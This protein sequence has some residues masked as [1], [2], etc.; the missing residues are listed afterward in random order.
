MIENRT[1][2]TTAQRPAR[3]TD[4]RRP[5]FTLI[6]LLVVILIILLVSAVTLPSI[7]SAISHRQVSEAARVLQAALVGARDSAVHNNAISGIRL[8][9]D[10][11]I[12]GLN[13]SGALDITLPLAM[14][15][16][17]PLEAAPDYDEGKVSIIKDLATNIPSS[18]FTN[19]T[20]NF[21]YP[22]PASGG[23]NVLMVEECPV[24][25][26]TFLPNEPT[27]WFW[28]IRIGDKIRIGN[29]GQYYTV[30]GPMT[31]PNPELFVNDGPAGPPTQLVRIY[32]NG[33]NNF[34]PFNVE[35]LFL[36]NGQDD[37]SDGFV[38]DGWDGVDNNLN[39]VID[40]IA[41]WTEPEK[42]L[43]S[44]AG[45]LQA[46]N[47]TVTSLPAI[48][49]NGTNAPTPGLLNQSY[50]IARRPAPSSGSREVAL[51]SNVVIDLT[52]WAT[53]HERSRFPIPAAPLVNGG[54][55]LLTSQVINPES[56]SVDILVNPDGTVVPST[57]YSSPSSFGLNGAFLHFWLA[58]RSDVA[59]PDPTRVANLTPP[60][61]PLPAGLAP[62]GWFSSGAQL[63]GECSLVT[64]Y[65][66]TGQIL[67]NSPPRFDNP[68]NPINGSY[69]NLNLP[70]LDAQQGAMGGNR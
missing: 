58:E 8:L 49:P 55:P 56:G 21:P 60:Y 66:R 57:V 13:S 41:E 40:E 20:W 68:A 12:N 31:Q 43:G 2:R 15:R 23:V 16:I 6:E 46:V 50:T 51:P 7:I 44:L 27:S 3:P 38:D 34:G 33:T 70:F 64:V 14:N 5:G 65:S 62:A 61:L 11:T 24:D 54:Q 53:S 18:P 48:P 47:A 52:T 36:V 28:N 59:T 42:W 22:Y 17:M 9:P 10:P 32:S 69:Y 45:S 35:Y 39:N 25:T 26:T 30:I 4:A 67:V 37:D 19:P 29:A 63:N 1:V